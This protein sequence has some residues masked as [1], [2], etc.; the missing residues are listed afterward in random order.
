[1][2]LS[3]RTGDGVDALVGELEAR[4]PDGP[5]YYPGGVVSDQ[6]ETF[7]VAELVREKLLRVA[8][9][10][11]PHSI[12]VVAEELEP[13]RDDDVL[14]Y[15]VKVLVERD[16]Q[17]GMVIGKGGHV[18]K[19]AGTLAARSSRRSSARRCSSTPR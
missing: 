10:E 6:P 5:E 9:D 11:L 3:G 7:L 17:K 8:R 18:I 12:T 15:E 13:E 1:M 16:S 14:R 19:Q 2:P 4:L